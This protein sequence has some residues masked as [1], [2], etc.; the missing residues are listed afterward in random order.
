ME[1]KI[2][3][4]TLKVHVFYMNPRSISKIPFNLVIVADEVKNSIYIR[5][6]Q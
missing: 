6:I 5:R 4:T 3:I 1:T 2:V